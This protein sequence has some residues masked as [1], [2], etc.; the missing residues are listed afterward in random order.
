MASGVP[1]GL[2]PGPMFFNIYI[3]DFD[4][5]IEC[6]LSKS[7]DDTKMWSAVDMSEGCCLVRLDLSSGPRRTS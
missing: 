1:Q 4:S 5:G 6:T 3:S 7:V 2:V